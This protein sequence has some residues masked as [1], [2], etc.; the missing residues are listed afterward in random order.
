MTDL[1]LAFYIHTKVEITGHGSIILKQSSIK[2]N[3]SLRRHGGRFR[4][5]TVILHPLS[6]KKGKSTCKQKV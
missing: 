2:I 1:I 4:R 5:N 3:Q 6:S